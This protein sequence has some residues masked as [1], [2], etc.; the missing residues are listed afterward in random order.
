MYQVISKL[1]MVIN[2]LASFMS[3]TDVLKGCLYKCNILIY[4]T[5]NQALFY[6]GNI[7]VKACKPCKQNCACTHISLPGLQHSLKIFNDF[8]QSSLF[9][10][11]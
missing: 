5:I 4:L 11:M 2:I 6:T 1:E 7:S 3:F 9:D 10:R 8:Y